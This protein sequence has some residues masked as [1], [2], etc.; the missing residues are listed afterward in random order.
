MSVLRYPLCSDLTLQCWIFGLWSQPQ[1]SK[2]SKNSF[3]RRDHHI[4]TN[5]RHWL[6]RC[7]SIKNSSS[8]SWKCFWSFTLILVSQVHVVSLEDIGKPSSWRQFLFLPST[9]F[10]CCH[11]TSGTKYP[12]T[13]CHIPKNGYLVHTFANT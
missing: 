1:Q 10:L 4:V 2:W 3:W 7:S 13:H 5:N 11:K 9:R 6:L 12:V 8:T